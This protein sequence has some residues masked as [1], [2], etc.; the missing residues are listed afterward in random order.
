MEGMDQNG[1]LGST[2]DILYSIDR[3]APL[4]M[5]QDGLAD[6]ELELCHALKKTL[7]ASCKIA[8]LSPDWESCMTRSFSVSLL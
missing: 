4:Q 1:T 6:L 2:C 7:E 5:P 3:K 8:C